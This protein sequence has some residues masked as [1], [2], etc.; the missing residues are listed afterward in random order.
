[1]GFMENLVFRRLRQEDFDS[2][3]QSL[4]IGMVWFKIQGF[5]VLMF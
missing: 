5:V 4:K 3:L 2:A 1:M